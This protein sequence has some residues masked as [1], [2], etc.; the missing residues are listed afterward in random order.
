MAA[1]ATKASLFFGEHEIPLDLEGDYALDINPSGPL[2]GQRRHR[3][4]TPKR[5]LLHGRGVRDSRDRGIPGGARHH[6]S[7]GNWP[8][9][10][11]VLFLAEHDVSVPALGYEGGI[12]CLGN[13][14]TEC[15]EIFWGPEQQFDALIYLKQ[16]EYG[17]GRLE[18]EAF[19]SAL[20]AGARWPLSLTLE[21]RLPANQDSAVLMFGDHSI[22]LDLRGMSGNA[23]V[24]DY[25]THYAEATPG[26]VLYESDGKTVVLDQVRHDPETGGLEVELTANNGSEASD[27]TPLFLPSGISRPAAM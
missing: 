24:F 26:S 10:L 6:I 15:L 23:P 13:G 27:F 5:R 20:K 8:V 12:V 4:R 9:E 18:A 2:P 1:N 21:F 25:T 19:D 17:R 11:A 7:H 22:P 16:H 3:R 14:G